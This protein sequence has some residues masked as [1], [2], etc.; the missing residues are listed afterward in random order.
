MAE[1]FKDTGGCS[2]RLHRY[3]Q[4]PYAAD[5]SI[6]AGKRNRHFLFHRLPA[7]GG[8]APFRIPRKERVEGM[9]RLPASHR[10]IF[11]PLPARL[12]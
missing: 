10:Y 9:G 12:A 11:N 2:G 4:F 1:A 6:P 8:T 7:L 5:K 3:V